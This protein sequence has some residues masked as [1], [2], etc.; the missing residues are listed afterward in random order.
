MDSRQATPVNPSPK[1]YIKN[2]P[3]TRPPVARLNQPCEILQH[4][5]SRR[6]VRPPEE[7]LACSAEENNNGQKGL[8]GVSGE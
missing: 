7:R 4:D 2:Q 8:L 6:S 1:P 5:S 3:Q